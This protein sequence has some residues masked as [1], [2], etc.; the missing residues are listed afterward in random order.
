[1]D[2]SNRYS[3]P[4]ISVWLYSI[5]SVVGWS[6]LW[7]RCPRV[8]EWQC[9]S[10]QYLS[11]L[12]EKSP[13]DCHVCRYI[14]RLDSHQFALP[15]RCRCCRYAQFGTICKLPVG[16]GCHRRFRALVSCFCRFSWWERRSHPIRYGGRYPS[17]GRLMLRNGICADAPYQPLCIAQLYSSWFYLPI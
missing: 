6:L 11:A 16:L 4:G 10:N 8:R 1:F 2:L 15:V 12:G 3:Y 9:R 7:R 17:R 13:I 5:G 14:Q